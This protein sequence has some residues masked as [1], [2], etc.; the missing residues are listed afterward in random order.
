MTT[1]HAFTQDTQACLIAANGGHRPVL[2]GVNVRG[3]LRG[4][5]LDMHVEQHYRNDGKTPIEAVYTFPLA[6]D[7]VLLGLTVEL[8]GKTLTGVAVARQ[9]AEEEYE[10]A[11]ANGDSAV[12]LERSGDGLYTANLGNLLPGEQAVIRFRYGQALSFAQG[13]LRLV[14]PTVIAPRYGDA[15]RQA[16]MRAGTVPTT[17]LLASYPF[18]LKLDI[19]P[20]LAGC[21]IASPS[22]SLARQTLADGTLQ[23]TLAQQGWLDRDLVVN[24][25]GVPMASTAV[26][27]R[28][29]DRVVAMATLCP[30]L[31]PVNEETRAPLALKILVDCSG[32]MGGDSIDAARRAL[33]RILAALEPG[34]SVSYSRFG[35]TVVHDTREP[36]VVNSEDR[37]L[38]RLAQCV[39]GTDANLGGTEMRKALESVFAL[40]GAESAAVLLITDGETWDIPEIIASAQASHQRVFAVGIGAAPAAGLLKNVAEATGGACEFVAPDE[41]VEGTVL[42]LFSRLRAPRVRDVQVTWPGKPAV[43]GETPKTL[44]GGET[45]HLFAAWDTLPQG[46]LSLR[47]SADG[48]PASL[49]VELPAQVQDDDTLARLFGARRVT[50]ATRAGDEAQATALAVQYQLV[51]EHTNYLVVHARADGDK[52]TVLPDLRHVEQMLAAGWG[53]SGLQHRGLREPMVIHSAI[54]SVNASMAPPDAGLVMQKRPSA[55]EQARM[56]RELDALSATLTRA[57]GRAVRAATPLSLLAQLWRNAQIEGGVPTE[58]DDILLLVPEAVAAKLSELAKSAGTDAAVQ[59]FYAA[60][61]ELSRQGV[62]ERRLQRHLVRAAGNA[63]PAWAGMTAGDWG[64]T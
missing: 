52:G 4:V 45:L 16:G 58:L 54:M 18:G 49:E 48:L 57:D 53:G 37:S 38:Y 10:E 17:N 43:T 50:A 1:R 51:S 36:V 60:L 8:D 62:G 15:E 33:H 24:I 64:S 56:D 29:G 61:L 63:T 22:H 11:I 47:W 30:P 34:D 32:S 23:L 3:T 46:K 5:L 13:N 41:D 20:P 35:S 26:L 42:R 14:V 9:Q 59:Q 44:F 27:A 40:G 2:T 21:A 39:A 28:D 31:P 19:A 55:R 12:M 25:D 7:A 6:H